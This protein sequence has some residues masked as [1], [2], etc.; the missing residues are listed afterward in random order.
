MSGARSP[1]LPVRS[2][3]YQ[4]V[5][6]KGPSAAPF[7]RTVLILPRLV[8]R[9]VKDGAGDHDEPYP[10]RGIADDARGGSDRPCALA[11]CLTG[12]ESPATSA[13][14]DYDPAGAAIAPAGGVQNQ[15]AG[16]GPAEEG[17]GTAGS[18]LQTGLRAA[19]CSR[20]H[21]VRTPGG[22]P[23]RRPRDNVVHNE[24]DQSSVEVAG[25][26][27]GQAKIH[28]GCTGQGGLCAHGAGQHAPGISR[29]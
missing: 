11:G 8:V 17:A 5:G 24:A 28:P 12:T 7:R 6:N 23:D 4:G 14:T 9:S 29:H 16:T 18:S 1:V 20:P 15:A 13:R 27:D 3:A 22:R 26:G 2:W 25:T 19:Q 10:T 21:R